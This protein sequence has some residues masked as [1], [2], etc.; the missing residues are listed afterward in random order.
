MAVKRAAL[1]NKHKPRVYKHQ[2]V[3]CQKE[4]MEARWEAERLKKE[5]T[6]AAAD[7]SAVAAEGE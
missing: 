6:D 2:C 3:E 4:E 7:D 1:C 5:E